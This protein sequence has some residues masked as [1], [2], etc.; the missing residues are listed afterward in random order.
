M[1]DSG[2]SCIKVAVSAC[3]LGEHVRYDGG[4]KHDPNIT[5]MM[6]ISFSLVPFCP[7]VECG[8]SIPRE[9]MRL[10]GDPAAPRLMTIQTP[11]DKTEQMLTYCSK[12]VR[13]LEA[14]NI[15]AF[16]FK[17]RSPSCAL[18]AAP[19]YESKSCAESTRGLFAGEVVRYFPFM[20]VEEAEPLNN[21]EIREEFINRV[22]DYY[23]KGKVF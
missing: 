18:N 3:L 16:I 2:H 6:G 21:S 22:A 10:E 8:L 4:H 11:D 23:E 14:E 15:S 1:P 20:P 13:E 9:T 19:L 7:E 5:E 17:E 12:K